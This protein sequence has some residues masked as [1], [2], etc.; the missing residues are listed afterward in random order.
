[1][2]LGFII[3]R[4]VQNKSIFEIYETKLIEIFYFSKCLGKV[5]KSH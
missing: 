2:I 1:M 4:V 5:I 3:S